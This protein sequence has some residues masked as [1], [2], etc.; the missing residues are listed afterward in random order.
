VSS[1]HH[2]HHTHVLPNYLTPKLNLIFSV[3]VTLNLAFVFAEVIYAFTAH[4]VSLLSDAVHNFADVIG[5]LMSWGAT[6][7]AKKRG[8][9][10]YSYG[11]KKLTILAALTNAL[12][13][14]FTSALIVYEAIIKL[15]YPVPINE[16]IVIVVAGIGILINGG[17]ALLFINQRMSDL[18]IKSAF[19]HLAYDA[20]IALGVL[21][22]A[23]VIYFTNWQWLDPV[24]ALMVVMIIAWGSWNLLRRSVEL[25]LGAVPYEVDAQAVTEYLNQLPGVEAVHDVHIWGMSTQENALTAHLI[26]PKQGLCDADY[27]KVRQIMVEKF[28]IQH[29]TLQVE[30]GEKQ[31]PCPQ[32]TLCPP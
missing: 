27:Q 29:V 22:A 25:I 11:Y 18:N 13:L 28:R 12:L 4:S 10:R 5:L 16:W 8:T 20:L 31:Y 14:V 17:T 30:R 21:L 2:A 1:H 26:M 32:A 24:V 6:F 15:R 19:L 3:A 23:T 7:L 9:A